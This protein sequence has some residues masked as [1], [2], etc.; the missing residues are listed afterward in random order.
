MQFQLC[1]IF[2]TFSLGTRTHYFG[3]TILHGG[4]R[5]WFTV[6]PFL[7]RFL[8]LGD[9]ILHVWTSCSIKQLVEDLLFA[10]SS[11]LRTTGFMHEV[12]LLRGLSHHSFL[13]LPLPL[14]L[15]LYMCVFVH[16][17]MVTLYYIFIQ[18]GSCA[19]FGCNPCIRIPKRCIIHTSH[20]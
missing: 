13:P 19:A 20:C 8:Y 7:W 16:F 18:N 11:S 10:T 9:P 2:F 3:R 6:Y 12:I 1:T 5:V 14:P 17:H 15:H 4:A